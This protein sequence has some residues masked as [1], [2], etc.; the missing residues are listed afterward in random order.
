MIAKEKKVNGVY[1]GEVPFSGT[2]RDYRAITVKTDGAFEVCV[3]L[4]LP[5]E[6]FGRVTD[7]LLL[8]TRFDGSP[9]SYAKFQ[10]ELYAA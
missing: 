9:S 10:D 2:I 5:V 1:M 7:T 8:H 6:A 3:D 4:D